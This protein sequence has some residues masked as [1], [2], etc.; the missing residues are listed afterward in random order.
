V[1]FGFFFQPG[2]PAFLKTLRELGVDERVDFEETIGKTCSGPRHDLIC[3]KES[4]SVSETTQNLSVALLDL[5]PC[6]LKT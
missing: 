6:M 3:G 1:F 5:K 4:T 2:R